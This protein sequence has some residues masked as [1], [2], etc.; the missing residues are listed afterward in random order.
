MDFS[1]DKQTL[2]D[3]NILGRYKPDSVF[4]IFNHTKTRGGSIMLEHM[5]QSPLTQPV[6]IESRNMIF[7]Y[8]Q[9]SDFSLTFTTETFEQSQQYLDNGGSP[10][11][12][13]SITGN[14]KRKALSLISNNQELEVLIQFQKKSVEL[15]ISFHQLLISIW[16]SSPNPK[17]QEE[18]TKALS[19]YEN[20]SLQSIF[21]YDKEA[22]NFYRFLKYDYLIRVKGA[23]NVKE[24]VNIIH[25]FDLYITVAKT[26]KERGFSYASICGMQD[27]K[28]EISGL[29]HPSIQNAVS[30]DINFDANYNVIFLTG[31]NMAGKSTLM[32]SY[33]IAT[34]LVHMGFPG[35]FR[36]MRFSP[37]QG[38]YTSINVPDNLSLGYSHFYAE[39]VR[40]KMIAQEVAQDKRLVIMFDE[41]FKGT[42]VKDAYEATVQITQAF[43]NKKKC[44]FIISTH[45]M[46][47]GMELRKKQDNIKFLLLPSTIEGAVPKYS[48]KLESGIS[49]DRHGMAIIRK[50]KILDLIK[51][52][53]QKV[54]N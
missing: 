25:K 9:D 17:V 29:Y 12:V 19:I 21:Q 32:K 22:G 24:L 20:P 4:N 34:Y 52:G 49:D 40:V 54:N 23:N 13:Q 47:A 37:I 27:N 15:L 6:E 38:I 8:F 11:L 51:A 5:F 26:G 50:E 46:E 31:A 45:I 28:I 39:V 36:S 48:Y 18:V 33:G 35:P 41:L 10:G 43:A 3:L 16:E 2:E 53:Q 42:N 1:I 14:I 7:S 30:N 44:S